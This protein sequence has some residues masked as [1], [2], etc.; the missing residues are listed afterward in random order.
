MVVVVVVVNGRA[1]VR[2]DRRGGWH[3]VRSRGGS[4]GG[5]VAPRH[6][7]VG[8]GPAPRAERGGGRPG[9]V[10][11]GLIVEEVGAL[12]DEALDDCLVGA[13]GGQCVHG[14]EVRAHQ[15]GPEADGQVLAGHQIQLTVLAH[16]V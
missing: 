9:H 8:R 15:R 14:G 6:A 13:C 7:G 3:D 4:G 16:L 12:L 11:E 2:D 10:S 1:V 5:G